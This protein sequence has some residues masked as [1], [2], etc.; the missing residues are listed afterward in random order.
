MFSHLS[1]LRSW[2]GGSSRPVAQ[3]CQILTPTPTPLHT[4]T[5]PV[6]LENES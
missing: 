4:T 3:K 6:L 2:P 5:W 1:L